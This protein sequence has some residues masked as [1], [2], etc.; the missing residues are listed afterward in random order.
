[1]DAKE[2]KQLLEDRKLSKHEIAEL[3]G[4][5]VRTVEGWLAG[6]TI[7][8]PAQKILASKKMLASVK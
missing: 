8:K 7:S 3:T 2:F 1:M 4:V 6:R 5:S